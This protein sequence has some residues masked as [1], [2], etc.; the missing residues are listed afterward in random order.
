[1][2]KDGENFN[3]FFTVCVKNKVFYT[4]KNP[5]YFRKYFKNLKNSDVKT[6]ELFQLFHS[7]P[8]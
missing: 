6:S 4:V 2:C 3:V 7:F 8:P 5:Q 1:M